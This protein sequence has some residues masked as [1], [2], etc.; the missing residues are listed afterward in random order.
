MSKLD[1]K[2]PG[3]ITWSEFIGWMDSEGLKRDK[4]HDAELYEKGLTRLVEGD[5]HK[6][7]KT[8][9][10]FR[11]D[12]LVPIR[13]SAGLEVVLAVFET[14]QAQFLDVKT[15]RPMCELIF[16][17]RFEIKEK[18][19]DDKS[20]RFRSSFKKEVDDKITTLGALTFIESQ[21]AGRSDLQSAES[22]D[23]TRNTARKSSLLKTAETKSQKSGRVGTAD[24]SK[25]S[26]NLFI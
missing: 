20:S 12:H 18:V 10:E 1:P 6:L 7:S 24:T 19:E 8:R 22:L 15:M 3:R 16:K 2:Q 13:V 25:F 11:I 21:D 9:T 4:R 23:R 26:R 14:H 17:D 5:T